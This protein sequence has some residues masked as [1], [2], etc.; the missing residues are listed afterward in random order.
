[1]AT[2]KTNAPVLPHPNTVMLVTLN[3]VGW[4]TKLLVPTSLLTKFVEMMSTCSLVEI[5]YLAGICE[6]V[7]IKCGVE[8]TTSTVGPSRVICESK[9]QAAEF[10]KFHDAAYELLDTDDRL[11]GRPVVT[12]SQF[13]GA[14]S[15]RVEAAHEVNYARPS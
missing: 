9:E 2:L 11:P 10:K 4:N 12:L 1:M 15:E 13:K 6:T 5:D 3:D 8:F 7:A 14:L